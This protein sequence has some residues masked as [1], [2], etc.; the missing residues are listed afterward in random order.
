MACFM[1]SD[2]D[3]TDV[4]KELATSLAPVKLASTYRKEDGIPTNIPSIERREECSKSK[5]VIKLMK[6][7]HPLNNLDNRK[8]ILPRP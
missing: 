8:N 3:E 2:L 6:G 7:G 5:D 1:V 4:A